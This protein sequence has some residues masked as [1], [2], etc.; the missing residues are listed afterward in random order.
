MG[1]TDGDALK[2]L[3]LQFDRDLLAQ[4]YRRTPWTAAGASMEP[5]RRHTQEPQDRS[6]REVL[7]GPIHGSQDPNL[8]A[9]VRQTLSCEAKPGGAEQGQREPESAASFW[10]RRRSFKTSCRS[11]GSVRSA[12]S[13]QT[14]TVGAAPPTRRRARDPEVRGDG[15]VPRALGEIPKPVIVALLRASRGRHGDDHRPFPHAAQLLQD[16][17]RRPPA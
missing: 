8:G 15:H 17:G 9:S 1:I 7:V 12:T 6:Q 3:T 13:R 5:T 2:R 10:T 4:A 14:T 16:D 11:S